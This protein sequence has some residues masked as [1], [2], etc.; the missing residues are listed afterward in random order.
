VFES[1]VV[2]GTEDG[3]LEVDG[4]ELIDG[5]VDGESEGILALGTND[6]G[7]EDGISDH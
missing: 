5:F 4:I 1:E 6:D 2:D 3:A 7:A